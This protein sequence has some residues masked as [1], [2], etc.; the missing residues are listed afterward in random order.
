MPLDTRP[1]ILLDF[2]GTVHA[3]RQGYQNKGE[4]YD[5][6]TEGFGDWAR[7]AQ[8]EFRIVIWPARAK[9]SV[10]LGRVRQW[11]KKHGLSDI[12]CDLTISTPIGVKLKIDDRA[13]NFTGSWTDFSV[14]RLRSFRTW[15]GR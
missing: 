8:K 13:L 4:Y 15:S 10:D 3:Y 7:E 1:V 2:N 14:E 12:D 5:T 9:T 6:P 11:L